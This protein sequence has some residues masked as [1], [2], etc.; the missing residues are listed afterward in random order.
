MLEYPSLQLCREV[1]LID[2]CQALPCI[3]LNLGTMM[4]TS[5]QHAVPMAETLYRLLFNSWNLVTTN[6]KLDFLYFIVDDRETATLL[7]LCFHPAPSEEF[8]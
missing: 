6:G 4:T 7:G 3:F 5:K 8:V 1:G 2:S